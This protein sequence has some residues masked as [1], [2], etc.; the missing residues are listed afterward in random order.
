MNI[1]DPVVN[2]L[3][4]LD[5]E[6]AKKTGTNKLPRRDQPNLKIIE[7]FVLFENI[8]HIVGCDPAISFVTNQHHRSKTTCSN[9]S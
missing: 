3:G 7:L 8:F 1:L 9:T 6:M 2:W 4:I 5:Q